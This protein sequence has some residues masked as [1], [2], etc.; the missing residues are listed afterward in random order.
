M[1]KETSPLEKDSSVVTFGILRCPEQLNR[2]PYKLITWS[3]CFNLHQESVLRSQSCLEP[4]DLMTF[5]EIDEETTNQAFNQLDNTSQEISSLMM[6]S[7]GERT[8]H[9]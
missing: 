2:W 7:L 1:E 6:T 9:T 5:D 8:A 3:D 4:C